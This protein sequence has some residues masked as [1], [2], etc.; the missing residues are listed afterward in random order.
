M[1]LIAVLSVYLIV[2]K[3]VCRGEQE[4]DIDEGLVSKEAQKFKVAVIGSGIGGASASHFLRFV[5]Y[6]DVFS[7]R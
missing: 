1:K 5:F 4:H 6:L 3:A 2:I 7:Q